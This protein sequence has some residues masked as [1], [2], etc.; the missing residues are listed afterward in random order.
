MFSSYDWHPGSEV[1]KPLWVR[2]RPLLPDEL[3][4]SWLVR[5]SFALGCSVLDIVA[6]VWP[7]W[8]VW[9]TDIDR[10]MP[11][12]R[13]PQLSR[14]SGISVEELLQATLHGHTSPIIGYSSAPVSTHPWILSTGS[15]NLIRSGGLQ[16]CPTC[17]DTD[18]V[19]YF[20][21]HWRFAWHTVCI[22]HECL[23][24]D[25]CGHCHS[26]I[27][28]HRK[29][30]NSKDIT[31]CSVCDK[32]LCF[33]KR[34][35]K[36]KIGEESLFQIAADRYLKGESAMCFGQEVA[37]P[38][39]FSVSKVLYRW[40][41]K[42]DQTDAGGLRRVL[43]N[44]GVSIPENRVITH[45]ESLEKLLLADRVKVFSYV[46]K[47]LEL[48]QIKLI[49][50]MKQE[51]VSRQHLIDKRSNVPSCID[52]I[53][54]QLSDI[55]RAPRKISSVRRSVPRPKYEVQKMMK[56]LVRSWEVDTD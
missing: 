51:G 6:Q 17:L 14:Y 55:T 29:T 50:M 31:L 25:R 38:E 3:I 11:L 33:D 30:S 13:L 16:Y 9:A 32:S 34:N 26:A 40:L 18:E 20:K 19:P 4:S 37:L 48:D 47:I 15:R 28:P 36:T 41:C 46:W 12:D 5:T 43:T 35:T 54:M 56:S 24:L 1:N 8:R 21:I 7:G 23:L 42:I 2:A 52:E 39:W 45:H 22:K 44:L 53:G 10:N 27:Q 49:E